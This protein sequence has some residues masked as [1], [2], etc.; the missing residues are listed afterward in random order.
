M[1]PEKD[2]SVAQNGISRA[3]PIVNLAAAYTPDK[4]INADGGPEGAR[5]LRLVQ[6]KTTQREQPIQPAVTCDR[7]TASAPRVSPTG[8]NL[9]ST[10]AENWTQMLGG[11]FL[12]L[13]I[14]QSI[15]ALSISRPT[16]EPLARTVG[17]GA[18]WAVASS[19][20]GG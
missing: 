16:G 15:Y 14:F 9:R 20:G 18:L 19:L 5:S 2:S 17:T 3:M 4:E 12:N 6:Q 7:K 11:L 13:Q 1:H 10:V 8:P